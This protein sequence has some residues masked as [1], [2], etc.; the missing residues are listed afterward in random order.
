MKHI[1]L[2]VL[3]AA[4]MMLFAGC[5]TLSG[6]PEIIKAGIYPNQL[7][8]GDEA[9]ITVELKDKHNVVRAIEGVVQEDQRITFD[10]ND[11][12]EQADEKAGD[13]LWTF[14]VKVPF[15]A[16]DG[17]FLLD[18]TAYRSDG[19]PVSVRDKDGNVIAL[20]RTVP[21]VISVDAPAAESLTPEAEEATG[22]EAPKRNPAKSIMGPKQ[23]D[24]E[25]EAVEDAPAEETAADAPETIDEAPETQEGASAEPVVEE[26]APVGEAA[27]VV[28]DATPAE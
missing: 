1:G 5:N 4:A 11:L 6:Q 3:A 17:K 24:S 13:G 12:G 23:K 20:Q 8:P 7:R 26:A 21:L 27:P 15:Q 25:G 16:P 22:E 2:P 19:N 14:G 10:L 28:E 18:L 9:L